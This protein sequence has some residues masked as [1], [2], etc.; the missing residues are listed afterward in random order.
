[1]DKSE[2][3]IFQKAKIKSHLA[4]YLLTYILCLL[5]QKIFTVCVETHKAFLKIQPLQ[6]SMSQ[7]ITTIPDV[8]ILKAVSFKVILKKIENRANLL[9]MYLLL[10]R[11]IIL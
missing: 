6:L 1:M 11:V 4:Q 5:C 3:W 8:N 2:E 7:C 9:L 10:H